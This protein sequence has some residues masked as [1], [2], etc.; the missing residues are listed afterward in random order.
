MKRVASRYDGSNVKTS[1]K[2]TGKCWLISLAVLFVVGVV[3]VL[4]YYFGFVYDTQGAGNLSPLSSFSTSS[5]TLCGIVDPSADSDNTVATLE[6]HGDVEL[7]IPLPDDEPV[8]MV[9]VADGY[10]CALWRNSSLFCWGPDCNDNKPVCPTQNDQQVSG[11]S[12]ISTATN[13][14]CVVSEAG[15]VTCYGWMERPSSVPATVQ[16]LSVSAGDAQ[17]CGV[18]NT[19]QLRCWNH[20]GEI[21]P[22]VLP[23][24]GVQSVSLGESDDVCII[25]ATG[26][27]YCSPEVGGAW[28]GLLVDVN[29]GSSS[30]RRRRGDM[31]RQR[32][33]ESFNRFQY[34]DVGFHTGCAIDING[35]IW[36][37]TLHSSF[38][39][40]DAPQ[41][42]TD[43][44]FV[45]VSVTEDHTC[46]LTTARRVFCWGASSPFGGVH[47]GDASTFN[48]AV[49]ERLVPC[50]VGL[51]RNLTSEC[52]DVDE[53]VAQV[54]QCESHRDC[55]NTL[56][57]YLCPCISGYEEDKND[58]CVD[59]DE[60]DP[61]VDTHT[62]HD[63]ATCIN[64]PQSFNC[65][66]KIGFLGD[67]WNCTDIDE[68]VESNTTCHAQAS[69]MNTIGSFTCTCNEGY[70]GDGQN[71]TD[72]DEC[73]LGTDLCHSHAYCNNTIGG[74]NC[75][76]E[77]NW[78]GDGFSCNYDEC[79][80]GNYTC[81]ANAHC[82]NTHE[83]YNC[84]CNWG[85][86]GNGTYCVDI[87]E[88]TTGT[89][90]CHANATCAN[91]MGNFTC[92]CDTNFV[93]NGYACDHDECAAGL[94]ECD[95]NALCTNTWGAYNCTCNVGYAGDGWSCADIDECAEG[96]YSCRGNS[97]CNNTIGWYMCPCSDGFRD[98][99]VNCNDIDECMEETDNCPVNIACV[100]NPGTFYCDC[101]LTDPSTVYVLPAQ[102]VKFFMFD[103][104]T[105][106]YPSFVIIAEKPTDSSLLN[107][108]LRS[109][110][111]V[112]C[113]SLTSGSFV[114]DY[115]EVPDAAAFNDGRLVVVGRLKDS[116]VLTYRWCSDLLCTTTD[117]FS[118]ADAG[119]N[120][121]VKIDSNNKPV[122][123]TNSLTALKLIRCNN[124]MCD[125][126]TITT[127]NESPS[128][129]FQMAIL[130][131]DTLVVTYRLTEGFGVYTCQ[132]ST[133]S[134]FHSSDYAGGDSFNHDVVL[135]SDGFVRIAFRD[136]STNTLRYGRCTTATCSHL[137][138]STIAA[139][140]RY[141]SLTLMPGDLP[142]I[143]HTIFDEN[144][145]V[146]MVRCLDED[147]LDTIKSDVQD[148][149]DGA[150]HGVF[151]SEALNYLYLVQGLGISESGWEATA[152]CITH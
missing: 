84:S 57:S 143:T 19:Y 10:G 3:A 60:C 126:P 22:A 104:P 72:V 67:G 122:I 120:S 150:Y 59:I 69:C 124:Y 32:R 42:I 129:F 26:R 98:D 54:Q 134:N 147:C 108:Q 113:T 46:A 8:E 45:Q 15:Y 16:F 100:N 86:E 127:L 50:G 93:G 115:A 61:A 28:T 5:S 92:T 1:T 25:S 64:V 39:A 52:V 119:F 83:S 85:W 90:T 145:R 101:P 131:D 27:L 95:V 80:G 148:D 43:V 138:Y 82:I 137:E 79:L 51:R 111:G 33:E 116:Q 77:V 99:S 121:R 133:C 47:L 11:I 130:L 13:T 135:G 106:H 37:F 125:V 110:T 2:P 103:Q 18:T 136:Q 76:C 87:D 112:S 105:T 144:R 31:Q 48:T 30:Q 17:V 58:I 141:V 55:V 14:S 73:A 53:C 109:C 114:G 65:S 66:C 63:N 149:G 75:T 7:R 20:E 36:C 38:T 139:D 78:D 41:D 142:V 132:D 68:C 88:C 152:V 102:P 81:D 107:V 62:C 146:E 117:K 49:Q 91:T 35:G 70:E 4:V 89:H 128:S 9:S 118:I 140:G 6:C 44:D 23:E 97:Y 123:L 71:C 151:Y 29:I 40:H 74:Y 24:G 94:D 56:G 34:V 96:T 12:A 21:T